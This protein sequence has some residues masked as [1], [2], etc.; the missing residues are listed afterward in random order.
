MKNES[1]MKAFALTLDAFFAVLLTVA[2]L[3]SLQFFYSPSQGE[4][5]VLSKTAYDF[6]SA[7]EA[8]GDLSY[9]MSQPEGQQA[10]HLNELLAR[11][12]LS[13]ASNITVVTYT[14]NGEL[15]ITRSTVA[16]VRTMGE[17]RATSKRVF[18]NTKKEEYYIATLEVSYAR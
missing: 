12:P 16:A 3:A 18:T 10:A 15:S 13:I 1:G 4:N 6:L 11:L 8:S 2:F 17:E 5:V 7:F 14:Y 9:A